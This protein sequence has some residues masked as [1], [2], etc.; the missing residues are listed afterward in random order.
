MKLILSIDGGGIRGIAVVQFLKRLEEILDRPVH[1]L[2]DTFIGTSVGGLIAI[3][4]A[5]GD[6]VTDCVNFCT[7]D[8]MLTIMDKSW[9]DKITPVQFSPKY[10]GTGIKK[11]VGKYIKKIP[12]KMCKKKLLITGYNLNKNDTR[13]FKSTQDDIDLQTLG[14]IT[15]AAPT[16]FPCIEYKSEW[17]MDGGIGANNPTMASYVDAVEDKEE[18]KILSI[19]TGYK[20]VAIDGDR[21]SDWGVFG[22]LKHNIT[23]IA[24]DAP[25]RLV[26]RQVKKLLGKK[27][28][29]ID[30]ECENMCMDDT[31]REN[32]RELQ[33]MGNEWFDTNEERLKIF[34]KEYIK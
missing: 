14:L 10:D 15:S 21:A 24:F 9:W 23:S 33:K 13:V 3:K 11:I 32:V 16:Y 12:M 25:L 26:D 28:L 30:G 34:F 2:F 18:F 27:Y 22:W 7:R 8:N 19:G 17:Y 4:L 29:R 5:S 31:S 6:S 1:L 20:N